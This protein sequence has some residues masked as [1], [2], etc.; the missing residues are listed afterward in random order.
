MNNF[1]IFGLCFT[2]IG[3]VLG[4]YGTYLKNWSNKV[5]IKD[6]IK[7]EGKKQTEKITKHQ[8]FVG[9]KLEGKIEDLSNKGE[10][11]TERLIQ[12]QDVTE[13]KLGEKIESIG[14]EVEKQTEKI[15]RHQDATQKKLGTSKE[16]MKQRVSE[17]FYRQKNIFD[18]TIDKLN[19]AIPTRNVKSNGEKVIHDFVIWGGLILGPLR[20]NKKFKEETKH[21]YSFIHKHETKEFEKKL[22]E[23]C[24][25]YLS[26][27][28]DGDEGNGLIL[29]ESERAVLASLFT[30]NYN[31]QDMKL[32][33]E[34]KR[35]YL[36]LMRSTADKTVYGWLDQEII[37]C[38]ETKSLLET[39][40]K[41][42]KG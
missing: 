42:A 7:E 10:K 1:Q 35:Q 32:Y 41:I 21:I 5:E 16:L 36:D 6:A 28:D 29:K 13:K 38:N 25:M 31:M 23:F 18:K 34:F 37:K 3:L 26:Q 24:K 39:I 27:I 12:H 20:K 4:T 19:L 33:F 2:I 30:T 40:E 14:S 9:D 8:D 22:N 17:I 15:I 11:Q